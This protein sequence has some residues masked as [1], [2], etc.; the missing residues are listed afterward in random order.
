MM[1][2]TQYAYQRIAGRAD[3]EYN[4]LKSA[5]LDLFD[6]NEV[7]EPF[8]LVGFDGIPLCRFRISERIYQR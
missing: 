7:I 8:N 1:L 4:R 2:D 5:N 6:S 3:I